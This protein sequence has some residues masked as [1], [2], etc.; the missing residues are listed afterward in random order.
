MS[1]DANRSHSVEAGPV[2]IAAIGVALVVFGVRG[3]Y[4]REHFAL[5]DAVYCVVLIV[6][7]AMFLL[8]TSYVF[9]HA[10]L[11]VVMP[12]FVAAV[13]VRGY[14]A[15]AVALGLSLIGIIANAALEEWKDARKPTAAD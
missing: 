3:F 13:L 8:V 4:L 7:A 15:F 10:R 14:P 11:V 12:L 9:Q 5:V 2:I 1:S 6:P